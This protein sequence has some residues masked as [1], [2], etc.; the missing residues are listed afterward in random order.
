MMSPRVTSPVKEKGA[1]V[2]GADQDGV[3]R[4]G[5]TTDPNCLDLNCTSLCLTVAASMTHI[6]LKWSDAGKG[7]EKWHIILVIAK[8][9][10]SLSWDAESL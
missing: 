6:K 3:E 4:E 5:G 7:T 10:M 2:D 9:K 8:G 1:D